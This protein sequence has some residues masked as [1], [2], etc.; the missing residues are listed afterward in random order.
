MNR[1]LQIVGTIGA[2][3]VA[4]GLAA[5]AFTGA[6]QRLVDAPAAAPATQLADDG[7]DPIGVPDEDG[8]VRVTLDQVPDTV[9]AVILEHAGDRTIHEIERAPDGSFE[10]DCGTIEF[11]V[12]ADGA[13]LGEEVEDGD[14]A[15]VP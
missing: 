9:R 12:G 6:R 1:N 13:Y 15:G 11:V 4:A 2:L 3:A 14:D 8:D 7:D 10:V 5:A